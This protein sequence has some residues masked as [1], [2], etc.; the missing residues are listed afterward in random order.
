MDVPMLMI[1]SCVNRK[2]GKFS[3][4]FEVSRGT[5]AEGKARAM[6]KTQGDKKHVQEKWRHNGEHG[7]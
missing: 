4:F 1:F 7:D 5:K 6:H 3:G 2:N